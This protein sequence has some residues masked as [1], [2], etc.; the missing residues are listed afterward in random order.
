[1][2][3]GVNVRAAFSGLKANLG[4]DLFVV[5]GDGGVWVERGGPCCDNV[6]LELESFASF[7]DG[8]TCDFKGS[9]LL[10]P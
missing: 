7:C 6:G 4:S 8:V 9:G 10:L 1:M 5:V 2:A 3:F